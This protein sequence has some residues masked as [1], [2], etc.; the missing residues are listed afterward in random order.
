MSTGERIHFELA[1][2]V[3][4]TLALRL[5]LAIENRRT[6]DVAP[7][8][9]V[10]IVGSLRRGKQQVGDIELLAAMPAPDQ[11][12][13]LFEILADR[14]YD[15][16]P[17][18][19]APAKLAQPALFAPAT[20]AAGI[21]QRPVEARRGERIGLPVKGLRSHF[22][23]CQLALELKRP[24]RIVHLDIWRYDPGEQGNRGWIEM[25]RTGPSD[26]G[27]VMLARWKE[28]R[29][30]SEFPASEDGYPLSAMGMRLPVPT[31]PDVFKLLVLP[32]VPLHARDTYR[33]P[34]RNV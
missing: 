13:P 7:G 34:R 22:R 10:A 31:E 29:G 26:F 28:V 9:T 24:E 1:F 8:L 25:I 20:P 17:T 3:V 33:L 27:Q 30:P 5:G 18:L 6:V 2:R 19:E 32:H 12:D 16:N 14:F 4:D 23:Y 11:A 15:P 21:A